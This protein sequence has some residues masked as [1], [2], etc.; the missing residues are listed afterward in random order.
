[1]TQTFSSKKF[2]T[3]SRRLHRTM[4]PGA[5]WGI[6]VII[7]LI[8]YAIHMDRQTPAVNPASY[9]QLLN[10]IGQVESADNYNAYFGRADN[11]EVEFTNMSVAEVLDWQREFVAAGH[12][13]SAVGRYQIMHTTLDELVRQSDIDIRQKFDRSMQD[14]L[15]IR[16]LE[17]RGSVKYATKQLTSEQ[18]AANLA[19]EWAALPRVVGYKSDAS[20]YADDGLNT[21]HTSVAD[22]MKAIAPISLK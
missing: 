15:A 11:Q 16:L 2:R 8:G 14:R 17:R 5:I 22:V 18:F 9:A 3:L 21:A 13:S 7:G 4:P 10:L 6:L 1:M 20:Y 12:A 19:Q